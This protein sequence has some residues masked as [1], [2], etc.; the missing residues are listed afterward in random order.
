MLTLNPHQKCPHS[1]RCQYSD[2]GTNICKGADTNR[3]YEFICTFFNESDSSISP[4]N[5]R[6]SLDQT[7][8]MKVILE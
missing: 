4:G 2:T 8:K 7:G 6:S 3:D 1:S 5:F